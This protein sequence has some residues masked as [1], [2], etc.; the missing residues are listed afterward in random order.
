M[1]EVVNKRDRL[2][3]V[4]IGRGSIWGNPFTV[5]QFGRDG[6]IEKYEQYIRDKLRLNPELWQE[7]QKLEG[8]VLGCFCKPK[9]CHGDILV[10]ILEEIKTVPLPPR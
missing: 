3:D 9:R 7:L 5:E 10:K 8:K 2:Y 4:Y 1:T 6:C